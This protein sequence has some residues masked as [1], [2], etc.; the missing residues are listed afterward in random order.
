MVDSINRFINSKK[1][2]PISAPA[3]NGLETTIYSNTPIS[4]DINYVDLKSKFYSRLNNSDV[5]KEKL[6]KVLNSY[7]ENKPACIK[8]LLELLNR[9]D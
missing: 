4:D 5:T 6:I 8:E 1:S 3:Q 9:E 7:V 2:S